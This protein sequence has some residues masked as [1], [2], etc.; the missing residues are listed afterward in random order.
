MTI[1]CKVLCHFVNSNKFLKVQYIIPK[2][3]TWSKVVQLEISLSLMVSSWDPC[4]SCF[5]L[6]ILFFVTLFWLLR[7]NSKHIIVMTLSL[8]LGFK[9]L[10]TII[11]MVQKLWM[12]TKKQIRNSHLVLTNI[13][14]QNVSP[15]VPSQRIQP[16]RFQ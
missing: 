4:S 2:F 11:R 15:E 5:M 6:L 10:W 16:V 8:W 13:L 7:K 12:K 14:N 9:K 1:M 3:Q